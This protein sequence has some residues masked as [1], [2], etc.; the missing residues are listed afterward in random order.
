MNKEIDYKILPEDSTSVDQPL[1]RLKASRKKSSSDSLSSSS[2]TISGNSSQSVDSNTRLAKKSKT[3]IGKLDQ[4][5]SKPKQTNDKEQKSSLQLESSSAPSSA[6]NELDEVKTSKKSKTNIAKKTTNLNKSSSFDNKIAANDNKISK[7][8]KKLSI[9]NDNGVFKVPYGVHPWGT[10][11]FYETKN[12]KFKRE[13]YNAD[14]IKISSQT[15]FETSDTNN[16]INYT[17]WHLVL[18]DGFSLKKK[19]E[20]EKSVI[21][22]RNLDEK[23]RYK[24]FVNDK[25]M[26]INSSSY[27]YVIF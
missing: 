15:I 3:K 24:L 25:I 27:N 6:V 14:E 8:I 17:D 19:T 12:L 26:D 4:D 5:D 23:N 20:D 21:Y 22:F 11:C 1:T 7:S 16:N 9:G 13:L 2:S 10:M 18:G